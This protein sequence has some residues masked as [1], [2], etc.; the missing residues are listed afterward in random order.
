M[1]ISLLLS[2][3]AFSL[4]SS[5]GHW[6]NAWKVDVS[7]AEV[8]NERNGTRTKLSNKHDDNASLNKLAVLKSLK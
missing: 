8:T 4:V 5:K 7:V 2:D 3:D 6:R 1:D